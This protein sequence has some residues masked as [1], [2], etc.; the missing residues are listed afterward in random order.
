MEKERNIWIA[1]A[2]YLFS[3]YQDKGKFDYL[4]LKKVLEKEI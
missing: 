4:R 1:D 2:G 3:A